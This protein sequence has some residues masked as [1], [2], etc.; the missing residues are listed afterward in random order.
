MAILGRE[1]SPDN[2]LNRKYKETN[3]EQTAVL[4]NA[5]ISFHTNNEDKDSDTHVTVTLVD[6][7]GIVAA[8]ISNDF[9]HFDDNSD[10]GPYALSVMNPSR[11]DSLQSGKISLRIDPNG[12]DTWRFNFFLDMAFS[13]GTRLSGGA[14]GL[15]LTQ[16]RREQ[17][18][19]IDGII[20]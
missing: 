20:R 2:R 16:N 5:R 12:H 13:D 8:R 9:G 6:A 10:S 17:T 3:R 18:Y 7:S 11:K 19:G 15:E 4:R 1:Y 14:D